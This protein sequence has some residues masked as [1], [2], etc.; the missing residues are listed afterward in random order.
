MV[1]QVVETSLVI[2]R[3]LVIEVTMTLIS[4]FGMVKG[5]MGEITL[6]HRVMVLRSLLENVDHPA[7]ILQLVFHRDVIG[8]AIQLLIRQ[9]IVVN[10]AL[11]M[12]RTLN[13]EPGKADRH[14]LL[15]K[16][17]VMSILHAVQIG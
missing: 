3:Q 4:T 15:L 12:K 14:R 6:L 9:E 1:P 11:K 10:G 2:V 17:T 8:T 5:H 16:G 7:H 13:Q